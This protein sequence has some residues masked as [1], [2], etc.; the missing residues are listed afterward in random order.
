MLTV[1]LIVTLLI[2]FTALVLLGIAILLPSASEASERARLARQVQDT[3]WNIHCQATTAFGEMLRATR[4]TETDGKPRDSSR[5][6]STG[7]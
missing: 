4:Q 1:I 7:Q 3:A 6:Q 2:V 5:S